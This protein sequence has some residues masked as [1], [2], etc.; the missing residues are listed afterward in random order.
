MRIR[1]SILTLNGLTL[2][3][4][5]FHWKTATTLIPGSFSYHLGICCKATINGFGL[6]VQVLCLVTALDIRLIAFSAPLQ[7]LK[8][9]IDFFAVIFPLILTSW[10]AF[11]LPAFLSLFSE[12]FPDQLGHHIDCIINWT[13]KMCFRYLWSTVMSFCFS[14]CVSPHNPDSRFWAPYGQVHYYNFD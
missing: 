3:I 13:K 1:P 2:W 11:C 12:V 8:N 10:N 6:S 7:S 5:N 14:M 4:G 9:Y